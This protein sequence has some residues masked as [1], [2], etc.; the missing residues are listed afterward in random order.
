MVNQVCY[1]VIGCDAAVLAAADAGQLELNVMMPV[2]A[3][4]VLHASRILRQAMHVLQSRCVAGIRADEERC[5]ELLDRSTAVATALSP[6]IGYAA[7]AEIAKSSVRTGR[8][9]RELVRERGLVAADRLD[10]ILSAEAIAATVALSAAQARQH[11]RLFPPQDLGLLE[12]PDRDAWQRPEN[13]MDALGIAE[14]KVVADL[15]AGGGWFTV[16]LARRVGPNGLVYAEDIQREMIVSI[17]NRI[18]REGLTNVKTVLGTADDPRLPAGVLDA[19]LIVDTYHEMEQP[20]D[21]LRKLSVSLRPAGLIGIVD[22][23]KDGGGP[24]PAMDERV[25]E[26]RV[27][28]DA[29]RA[30]LRV[31]ARPTFLRYQFMLVLGKQTAGSRQ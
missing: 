27:V 5:R 29:R 1:Q 2:I 18:A 22:F 6:Y 21:L 12:G 15:G 3:W 24:G 30:G 10:A 25:D 28:A 23:K 7:T 14:N 26:E 8:P 11:I 13:I 31:A 20:V 19:A 16:R 9:V 17:Q 4:N